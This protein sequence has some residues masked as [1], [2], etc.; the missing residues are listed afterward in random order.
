MFLLKENLESIKNI[1]FTGNVFNKKYSIHIFIYT[2]IFIY[3]YI[4]F[5]DRITDQNRSV[6]RLMMKKRTIL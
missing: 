2:Y 3:I 1:Q 6:K 5:A 4:F